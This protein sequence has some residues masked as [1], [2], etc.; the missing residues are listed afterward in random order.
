MGKWYTRKKKLSRSKFEYAINAFANG[1][2]NCF[3]VADYVGCSYMTFKKYANMMLTGEK[4]PDG[5]FED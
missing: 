3:Q 2:M 4:I 5:I 1:Q